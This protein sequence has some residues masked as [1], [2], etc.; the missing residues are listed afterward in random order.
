V[1]AL[2][3]SRPSLRAV[4]EQ[5]FDHYGLDVDERVLDLADGAVSP[6]RVLSTG[7]GPPL[8][9]LHGG[10]MCASLWA[11]L[12][13]HLQ[14]RQ[15]HCVDLPGCGLTA[16]FAYA[17]GTDLREHAQ[18]FVS[19]VLDGLGLRTAAVGGNSLG[20]LYALYAASREPDRVDG[21][22]LIGSP[23]VALPGARA[24]LPMAL[25]GRPRLGPAL[26][27]RMPRP[28]ASQARRFLAFVGGK[29]STEGH[30][31]ALWELVAAATAL[32]GPTSASLFAQL[33]RWRTPLPELALTDAE[34]QSLDVPALW[35]WGDADIF[36]GPDAGRRAAERM[37]A[38]R[39][40]VLPGGH[41]PWFDDP[42]RCGRLVSDFLGCLP[43][44]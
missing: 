30:P 25:Y 12:L 2:P 16:P 8:L 20:G 5:L 32:S 26:S 43:A 27:R 18:R 37:P 14:E 6:V 39:F 42:A 41:H 7:A 13:P 29:R 23:A 35:I 9:L 44:A 11:P 10:G 21:L 38:A 22:V 24:T 31:A 17:P 3:R 19:A 36:L 33:F 1:I 40:E 34:L 4:E 15:V 28:T